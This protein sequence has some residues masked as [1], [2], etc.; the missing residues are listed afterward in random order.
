MSNFLPLPL[1]P[2][3]LHFRIAWELFGRLA[4]DRLLLPGYALITLTKVACS[5]HAQ[6]MLDAISKE[7]DH[8]KRQSTTDPQVLHLPYNL[9]LDVIHMQQV[10]MSHEGQSSTKLDL[11]HDRTR[12]LDYTLQNK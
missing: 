11:N 8:E 7:L 12:T 2:L 5:V 10:L 4:A 1:I 6:P 3:T 9:D